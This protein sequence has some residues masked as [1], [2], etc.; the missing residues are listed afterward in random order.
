MRP[1]SHAKR[2][3]GGGV[4]GAVIGGI[5][6]KQN[7]ETPEGV[8]IGGAVGAI[9]GGLIGRAQDN[10]LERQRYYQQQAYNQQQQQFYTQQ[11][12]LVNSGVST[13]DVVSM[14]RSGLSETLIM[15]HLQTKG[16]QR[17]LEVSDII[18]LHQQGVSD[19]VITAYQSAPLASAVAT[20]A[21]N[22]QPPYSQPQVVVQERPVI[23]RSSPVVVR[24]Y[25]TPYPAY[26]PHHY[27]HHHGGGTSIRIG[28]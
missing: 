1:V 15:T 9:T 10:E 26:R 25:Y 27:H 5:V 7:D 2:S 18:T 23:Y 3:Y 28:F 8:L 24:E 12:A 22:F 19:T 21:P 6:G 20:P 17:R 14:S 11:Q 13:A 16:V 4:A